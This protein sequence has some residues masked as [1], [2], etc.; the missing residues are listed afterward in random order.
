MNKIDM[1]FV[2]ACK[3]IIADKKFLWLYRRFYMNQPNEERAYSGIAMILERIVEENFPMRTSDLVSYID[4]NAVQWTDYDELPSFAYRVMRAYR[5]HI[6][7]IE[8][9]ELDK[10]GYIPPAYF[11]NNI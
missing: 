6:F 3:T 5:L 7:R 4:P 10:L 11:R 8:N 9:D 2:R 1:L